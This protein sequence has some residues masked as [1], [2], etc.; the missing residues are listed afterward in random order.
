MTGLKKRAKR[1]RVRGTKG[2][3]PTG[4]AVRKAAVDYGGLS[5][6]RTANPEGARPR[7]VR[8]LADPRGAPPKDRK[9]F[10]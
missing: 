7:G 1:A 4:G 10:G 3:P 8:P 2:S 9:R 5:T 6:E